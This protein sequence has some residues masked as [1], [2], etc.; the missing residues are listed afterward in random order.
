MTYKKTYTKEEVEEVLQWL[1]D[2]PYSGSVSVGK[3]MNIIDMQTFLD[4]MS[5]V[6]VAQYENPTF[7]GQ[8][9]LLFRAKNAIEQAQNKE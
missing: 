7:G 6:A 5:N 1:K 9:E 2:H 8:I 4:N 3:G